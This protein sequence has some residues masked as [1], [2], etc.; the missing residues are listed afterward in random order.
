MSAHHIYN[1]APLG[2]RT[3][4]AR[5]CGTARERPASE[6]LHKLRSGNAV[7]ESPFDPA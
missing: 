7:A 3:P 2:S 4:A 6:T 1:N 5:A